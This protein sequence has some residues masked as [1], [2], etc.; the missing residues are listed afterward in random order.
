VISSIRE[1]STLLTR[2]TSMCL[3]KNE[4]RIV[5][6]WYHSNDIIFV[7]NYD[8]YIVGDYLHDVFKYMITS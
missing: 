6:A 5:M 7:L 3:K 4:G 2:I 8:V 1:R